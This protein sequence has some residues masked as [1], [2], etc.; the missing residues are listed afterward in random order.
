MTNDQSGIE[1]SWYSKGYEDGKQE[2]SKQ[3]VGLSDEELDKIYYKAFDT[4][5][6]E[7][8]VEFARAIEAKLKDKNNENHK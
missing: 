7:V 8:D 1:L 2:A 6:S 3:W 4:W 5:S